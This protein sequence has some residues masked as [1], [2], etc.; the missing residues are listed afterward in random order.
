LSLSALAPALATFVFAG[1]A[2]AISMSAMVVRCRDGGVCG[3]LVEAID[4][5]ERRL[6]AAVG[7]VSGRGA[8]DAAWSTSS[9][10]AALSVKRSGPRGSCEW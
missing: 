3:E 7:C 8:G 1:G 9:R 5:G 10:V 2:S 6:V 4:G